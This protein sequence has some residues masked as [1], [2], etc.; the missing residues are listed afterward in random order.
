M[1]F[2]G[3]KIGVFVVENNRE[4]CEVIE[5]LVKNEEDMEW[6]GVAYD[7][8][9]ALDLLPQANP[10]VLILDIIMPYLDGFGVLSKLDELDLKKRPKTIILTAFEE[11]SMVRRSAKLGADYYLLKPFD[12]ESLINRIRLLAESEKDM[13]ASRREFKRGRINSITEIPSKESGRD[14]LEAQ[15]VKVLYKLGV[16]TYFKGY[17]YLK[18]AVEMVI[19]DISLLGAV[20]KSLYPKIAEMHNTTPLIVE[21]AI[22]YTIQKTWHQ[23]NLDYMNRF[24]GYTSNIQTGKPPTNSFFIAK[25]SEEIRLGMLEQA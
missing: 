10:D 21:A 3:E 6:L 14:S 11:E 12:K 2:S 19:K 18:D 1:S 5:V 22:R 20:T 17:Q 9:E 25:V 23:G 24:F 7:G 15:V 16:P 13:V 4:L 8:A